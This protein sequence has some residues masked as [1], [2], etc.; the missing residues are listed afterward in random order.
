MREAP[1]SWEAWLDAHGAALFLFARSLGCA[2]ADAEDA[3]QE[4]FLRFW[5]RRRRARDPRAYLFRCVHSAARDGQ[6]AAV[7][8]RGHEG[9]A[10]PEARVWFRDELERDEERARLAEALRALPAEQREVVVLHAIAGLT[11]AAAGEV[12]G[13]SRHT[14]AS[15]YRYAL[16][17]LERILVGGRSDG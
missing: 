15:R 12:L 6:R 13:V 2:D 7:R 1:D 16:D 14:A 9:A 11:F 3:V 4:G 5:P 8:R 10:A 17:K